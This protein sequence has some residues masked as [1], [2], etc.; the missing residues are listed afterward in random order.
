[1]PARSQR[2]PIWMITNAW[3]EIL[4]RI[5]ENVD[6]QF[7]VSPEWLVNPATNRRLKLDLFY[8]EIGVAVRLEGLQGKQ[9]KQRLSLEEEVQARDRSNARVEACR[10]RGIQLILVDLTADQPQSTFQQIDQALSRAA[11]AID[12]KENLPQL[13]KSRATAS[14][15]V[16]KIQVE[17]DLKLY[18]DLWQDRQYQLSEPAQSQPAAKPAVTFSEGMEVEHTTFGPGVILSTSASNGDTLL[19]VDFITAGTKTL[20]ASLVADKLVP[21]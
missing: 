18:A 6:T 14:A 15:L 8:P 17:N 3:R 20:A 5:F 9:R 7:N 12:N 10:A 4:I 19:T 11:Q 13:K 1:M 21:R 16:H 2:L